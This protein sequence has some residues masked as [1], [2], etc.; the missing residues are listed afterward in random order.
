[1][2]LQA[3]ITSGEDALIRRLTLALDEIGVTVMAAPHTG[4]ALPL[5]Q[6]LRFEAVVVDFDL[7]GGM[8][9]IELVRQDERNQR[10]LVLACVRSPESAREASRA[11]ANFILSK[12]INWEIAK[13]TLRAAQS[14]IVRER[15]TNIREKV[16]TP[17]RFVHEERFVDA[18]VT[19]MSG[20]GLSLQTD[21]VLAVGA[22]LKIEFS[23]PG[24]AR[25]VQ[26]TSKVVWAKD[27]HIGVQFLYLSAS[28]AELIMSWLTQSSP[29]YRSVTS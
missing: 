18:H 25:P 2:S 20:S 24:S 12:P 5:L 6:K 8:D 26:C 14:M 17:A 28:N 22:Q 15:R 1:M 10:A 11:G 29:R 19:D 9:L 7:E 21:T 23:L 16:R 4:A 13:R 27:G 3:L